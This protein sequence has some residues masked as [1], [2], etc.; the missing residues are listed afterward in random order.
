MLLSTDTDWAAE[1]TDARDRF[2]RSFGLFALSVSV[3]ILVNGAYQNYTGLLAAD[4]SGA[5]SGDLS[6]AEQDRILRQ[7]DALYAGYYA[8]VG[9]SAGL[10]GN[11]IWRLITYVRTAQ[12][13]HT[14]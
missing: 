12:G 4:G 13:Y 6:A 9:L 8:G 14:R 3:P 10:F 1:V 2:Y 11:M 7:A 5:L